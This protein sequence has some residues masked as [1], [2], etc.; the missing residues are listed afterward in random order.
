MLSWLARQGACS[1]KFGHESRAPGSASWVGG[2]QKS[3]GKAQNST[4]KAQQTH[5]KATPPTRVRR[6]PGDRR[7]IRTPTRSVSEGG[8]Y[9]VPLLA[10]RANSPASLP[11]FRCPDAPFCVCYL[12]AIAPLRSCPPLSVQP[13]RRDRLT[14]PLA[15]REPCRYIAAVSS[16]KNNDSAQGRRA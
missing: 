6:R 8:R 1:R 13:L 5:R 7:R 15:R 4:K 3:A 10:R 16:T 12:G 2:K 9:A 14:L 11:C